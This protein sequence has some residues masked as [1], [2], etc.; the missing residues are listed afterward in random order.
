MD[1][2]FKA[3]SG[4]ML[5]I[6]PVQATFNGHTIQRGVGEV[7]ISI[8]VKGASH[9]HVRQAMLDA[10]GVK[11]GDL[12]EKVDKGE[13]DYVLLALPPNTDMVAGAYA[14]QNY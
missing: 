11:Y 8:L 7:D 5:R 4:N 9:V 3:C 14:F 2:K 13:I 10:A 6:E 12:Q 1:T